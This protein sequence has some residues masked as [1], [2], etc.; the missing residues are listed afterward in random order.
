MA[1]D[2]RRGRRDAVLRILKDAPEPLGIAE[3]AERIAAHPN[4]VRFHLDKL[5][6][7]G[8]VERARSG[9]RVP[10]RPAQVF[11]AV[12]GMDPAGPR[13]YRLL[14]D[15]LAHGLAAA[16]DARDRAV[17]AGRAWGL[18]SAADAPA[19]SADDVERLT[20]LLDDLGFAPERRDEA[21]IGLRHCPFLE[22][23]ESDS[24]VVCDVHLGLMRGAL[25]RWES[26]VTVDRLEAFAEPGLC[27]AVTAPR[28]RP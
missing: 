19:A 21:R 13:H 16:P 20:S 4:T 1:D 14:A 24:P 15:A 11:R 27:L 3:I 17:E 5:V 22:L 7:A 26:P 28:A 25:E 6:A 12:R 23:A 10:G 18:R 9:R 8:R 2:A